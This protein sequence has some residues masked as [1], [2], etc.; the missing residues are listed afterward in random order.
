M[1]VFQAHPNQL[2]IALVV[3]NVKYHLEISHTRLPTVRLA[4]A[5]R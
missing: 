2:K 3:A 5:E 4:V 1:L